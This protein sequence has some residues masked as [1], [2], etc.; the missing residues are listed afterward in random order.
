MIKHSATARTQHYELAAR[1]EQIRAL[2]LTDRYEK[3][4]QNPLAHWAL[5]ADRRLPR[6]LMHRPLGDLLRTSFDSLAATPGIGNKKMHSL[7]QLLDRA[8]RSDDL[9]QERLEVDAASAGDP[10]SPNVAV[11]YDPANISE[12][13]WAKWRAVVLEAGLGH[14]PLGRF[15]VTLHD[16]PRVIWSTPLATYATL[17]LAEIRRLKTHGEK[18][19]RRVVT[20]FGRLYNHVTEYGAASV[21]DLTPKG[22]DDVDAWSRQALACGGLPTEEELRLQ[23]IVPVVDQIRT[24]A[25]EQTAGLILGRLGWEGPRISVRRAAMRMRL[26]RARIYQLLD[27]A[28]TV[29]SV[30]WPRGLAQMRSLMTRFAGVSAEDPAHRLLTAAAE[31]FF[32]SE[33]RPDVVP[34]PAFLRRFE[35]PAAEWNE[36]PRPAAA[37]PVTT[38][39]ALPPLSVPTGLPLSALSVR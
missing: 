32:P 36:S 12:V 39:P 6:A 30:R 7:L 31:T 28:A 33:F 21:V 5:P 37:R 2:L 18:R 26:T 15:A 29:V 35:T 22:I 17:T 10:A 4:L 23:F 16:L 14:E 1:F 9:E 24:D 3:R 25:G 20:I 13:T 8:L 34:V 27:D 11:P 38:R 19:V